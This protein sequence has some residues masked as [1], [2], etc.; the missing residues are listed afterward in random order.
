M[1]APGECVVNKDTE[2]LKGLC[3]ANGLVVDDHRPVVPH[4][5]RIKHRFLSL[6]DIQN[7]MLI[8]TPTDKSLG[9]QK[10]VR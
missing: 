4:P 1:C 9:F 3:L 10:V 5:T 6:V 8:V 2:V 7:Q